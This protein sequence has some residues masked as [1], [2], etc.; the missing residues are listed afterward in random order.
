MQMVQA[1]IHIVY[2]KKPFHELKW[3]AGVRSIKPLLTSIL[4]EKELTNF[5]CFR[6]D[7][8]SQMQLLCKFL[9]YFKHH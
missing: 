3:N 2:L 4:K 9:N 6:I 7:R 1:L 5:T 8:E